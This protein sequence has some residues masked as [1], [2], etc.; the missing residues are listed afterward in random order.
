MDV[1]PLRGQGR[2]RVRGRHAERGCR[3]SSRGCRCA[4]AS[5]AR[6]SYWPLGSGVGLSA[7][8]MTVQMVVHVAA[9]CLRPADC[10]R[11]RRAPLPRRVRRRRVYRSVL[12]LRCRRQ[13]LVRHWARHGAVGCRSSAAVTAGQSLAQAKSQCLSSHRMRGAVA[14]AELLV[15]VVPGDGQRR[16]KRACVRS[17]GTPVQASMNAQRRRQLRACHGCALARTHRWLTRGHR[18]VSIRFESMERE[19]R[20]RGDGDARESFGGCGWGSKEGRRSSV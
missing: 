16:V 18:F 15:V 17:G 12:G 14:C 1:L 10:P 20:G 7:L 11:Q 3:G 9:A 6:P 13:L 8:P 4:R 19:G 5:W 2:A